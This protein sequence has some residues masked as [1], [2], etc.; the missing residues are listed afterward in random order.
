[1]SPLEVGYVARAHGLRGEVRVHLHAAGSTALFDVEQVFV[2]GVPRRIVSAR[3]GSG[4]VLVLFEGIDDRAGA[5]ALRGQPVAVR[6]ED[7]PLAEGEYFL[8]DLPG[9]EVVTEAGEPLGAVVAVE[10][11][12]QDLLVIQDEQVER[13][14][15]LVP[16]FVR[17]VDVAARRIVVELPEDL[18]VEPRRR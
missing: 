17:S 10:P 3:A 15:P 18:P 6:R 16:E 1:M 7:V 4:A 9:C 2:G 13:L 5:E 8:A 12:A 14:L 11:G